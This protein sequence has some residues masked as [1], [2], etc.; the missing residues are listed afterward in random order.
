MA[1]LIN[2]NEP[3]ALLL[4][5]CYLVRKGKRVGLKLEFSYCHK[6]CPIASL[7]L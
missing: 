7:D 3:S 1:H 5:M 6:G 4:M 2:M